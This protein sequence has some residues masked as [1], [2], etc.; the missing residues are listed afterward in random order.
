MLIWIVKFIWLIIFSA[1]TLFYA[2]LTDQ[3]LRENN[4]SFRVCVCDVCSVVILIFGIKNQISHIIYKYWAIDSHAIT[5]GTWSVR[6]LAP[7]S[8]SSLESLP[9]IVLTPSFVVYVF[10]DIMGPKVNSQTLTVTKCM[11]GK[12][13]APAQNFSSWVKHHNRRWFAV[14][15]WIKHLNK[16]SK[17][18]AHNF[19]QKL[20]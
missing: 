4:N 11:I 13:I 7:V 12:T 16:S 18:F 8:T 10:S 20:Y 2:R 5:N 3:Y 1:T 14:D 6:F 17:N 9:K 15:Q 19:K